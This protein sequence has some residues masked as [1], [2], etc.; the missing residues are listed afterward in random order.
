MS[1]PMSNSHID[2]VLSGYHD[3][4]TIYPEIK[5][6][7]SGLDWLIKRRKFGAFV[8]S[9]LLTGGTG[10]GKSALIKY[11]VANNLSDKGN[12]PIN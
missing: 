1:Q 5:K 6:V 3:S 4:F 10:A 11:Y 12:P 2:L 8:P 9:M 7:F